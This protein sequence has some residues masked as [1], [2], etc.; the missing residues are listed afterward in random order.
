MLWMCPF[1]FSLPCGDHICLKIHPFAFKNGQFHENGNTCHFASFEM[2]IIINL[3]QE[4]H[5]CV[6]KT[7]DGGDLC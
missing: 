3:S 2:S 5:Y 6:N 4:D 1:N 7:I